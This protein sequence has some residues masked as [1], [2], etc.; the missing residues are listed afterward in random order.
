MG[1]MRAA[2]PEMI[3]PQRCGRS[4]R[5]GSECV[6]RRLFGPSLASAATLLGFPVHDAIENRLRRLPKCRNSRGPP[7]RHCPDRAPERRHQKQDQNKVPNKGAGSSSAKQVFLQC[8]PENIPIA[9]P[10]VLNYR[11][12]HNQ[13]GR[14]WTAH[15]W[16]RRFDL[17]LS[18]SDVTDPFSAADADEVHRKVSTVPL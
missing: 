10:S 2:R 18:P 12:G 17:P 11:N 9:K 13:K 5:H 1:L 7:V 8:R 15:A 6:R 14:L 16:R 3:M 4:D